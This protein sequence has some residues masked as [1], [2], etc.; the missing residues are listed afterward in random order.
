MCRT[1]R[2]DAKIPQDTK[3]RPCHEEAGG[4][5]ADTAASGFGT[6]TAEQ[7]SVPDVSRKRGHMN[8]RGVSV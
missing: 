5:Q 6:D 3:M 4:I 8:A 1:K 7:D 2:D